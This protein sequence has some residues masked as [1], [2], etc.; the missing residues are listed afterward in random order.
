MKKERRKTAGR[1]GRSEEIVCSSSGTTSTRARAS[2]PGAG[3]WPE[4]PGMG[5]A[6]GGGPRAPAAGARSDDVGSPEPGDAGG[7]T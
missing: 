4:M 2:A 5:V 7:G 3:G 6:M 1:K